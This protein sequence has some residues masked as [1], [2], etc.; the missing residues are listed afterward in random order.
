VKPKDV[1][2]VDEAGHNLELAEITLESHFHLNIIKVKDL[3]EAKELAS[4]SFNNLSFI[5]CPYHFIEENKKTVIKNLSEIKLPILIYQIPENQENWTL[6][7]P[8]DDQELFS[9]I[10]YQ[11]GPFH[12]EQLIE[13][14]PKILPIEQASE[15]GLAQT[16]EGL[17][18]VKGHFLTQ[19]S[20]T[21]YDLYL[22]ISPGKTLQVA[23]KDNNDMKSVIEH[24]SKKDLVSFLLTPQD[25]QDFI[26][27]TKELLKNNSRPLEGPQKEGEV[28]VVSFDQLDL[29]FT[30][31]QDQFKALHINRIH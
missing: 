25:Y 10:K 3:I 9:A 13:L 24:Y 30:V 2:V 16:K 4:K 28:L 8:E 19:F 20:H 15:M 12:Q 27:H 21:D 11:R 31:A 22:E 18:R 23:T 14:I 5:L 7:G 29:A 17:K 26:E 6:T 1:F